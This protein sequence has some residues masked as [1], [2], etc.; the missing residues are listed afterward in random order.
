MLKHLS[1]NG[2]NTAYLIQG[3]E[4]V[5]NFHFTRC[6]LEYQG[7]QHDKPVEFFGGQKAFEENL[8][9]DERKRQLCKENGVK[10]IEV[11]EG[12]SIDELILLIT[13]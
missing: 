7:A 6:G 2:N 10:L 9:R 11:R 3:Q 8:K 4:F 12:Y 13:E 5:L 1:F